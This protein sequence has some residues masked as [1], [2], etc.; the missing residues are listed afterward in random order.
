MKSVP[1]VRI[2][3]PLHWPSIFTFIFLA[4]INLTWLIVAIGTVGILLF[5]WTALAQIISAAL[6]RGH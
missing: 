6:W 4:F 2:R 1:S 3:R 5:G